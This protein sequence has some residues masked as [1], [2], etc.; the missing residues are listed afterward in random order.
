MSLKLP[1]INIVV[2]ACVFLTA[3]ANPADAQRPLFDGFRQVVVLDPGHGGNDI[4]A[5]GPDGSTEK[6]IS[7][8]FAR[9]LAAELERNYKVVLTRD[10]D[11]GL[12]LE[13]RTALANHNRGKILI[14]IHC[15]G[16]YIRGTSGILIYLYQDFAEDPLTRNET[17]PAT[18]QQSDSP[19]LWNQVQKR[20]RED[21]LDLADRLKLR[22]AE[23]NGVNSIRI[24]G[25]PLLV[26]Q[27]ANMPAFLIE[28]GYLSNPG[29]EKKLNDQRYLIDMA[30][31]IRR[32][33]DDYFENQ[34]E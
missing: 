32:G 7:L 33:I 31:S 34:E 23:L 20:F 5:T 10:D 19:L 28:I 21:S 27:G 2:S 17:L 16:S 29:E 11:I 12:D 25:A 3:L 8:N 26:L 9:I 13:S 24:Q 18:A 1:I 4:G 14:S 6:T 30:R 22:L 15:G